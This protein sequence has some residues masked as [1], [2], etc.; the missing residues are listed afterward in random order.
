MR[1]MK[2]PLHTLN[3]SGGVWRVKWN[4]FSFDSILTACMHGGFHVVNCKNTV[5]TSVEPAILTSYNNHESIAY[6][7]DW[8]HLNSESV[9]EMFA[10]GESDLKSTLE[11]YQDLF[12]IS[13]CSFYDHKLCVSVLCDT[14][15]NKD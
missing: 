7:A 13:T 6:G 11:S 8:S 10:R 2:N 4:P 14:K 3:L 5:N 9:K 12:L 1:K 15:I